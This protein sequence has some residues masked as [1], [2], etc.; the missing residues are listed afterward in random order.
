M[1]DVTTLVMIIG[2]VQTLFVAV[3]IQMQRSR[4]KHLECCGLEVER[5]PARPSDEAVQSPPPPSATQEQV[6]L[7][8]RPSP[9]SVCEP[10]IYFLP[11]SSAAAPRQLIHV[12]QPHLAS[13]SAPLLHLSEPHP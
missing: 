10:A 4:I 2:V 8:V 9:L 12:Q 11:S 7:S 13:T 1:I 5:V 3:C 6:Q